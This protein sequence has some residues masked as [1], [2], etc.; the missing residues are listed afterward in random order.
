MNDKKCNSFSIFT[1]NCPCNCQ[2][3]LITRNVQLFIREL[4]S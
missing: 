4:Q 3:R 1:K 2:L